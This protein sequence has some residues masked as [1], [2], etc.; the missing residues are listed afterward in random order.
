MTIEMSKKEKYERVKDA[1]L[2]DI[3]PNIWVIF[4]TTHKTPE[5]FILS[6]CAILSLSGFYSGAKDTNKNTYREFIK[7]LFPLPY[8]P[9]N[10]PYNA[11]HLYFDIRC[12]LIHAYT[13]PKLYIM[14]WGHLELHLTKT[15]LNKDY[16]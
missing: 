4:E 3:L 7:D 14:T 15:T 11:D 5:V 6:H 12:N 16:P 10:L 9:D 8:N 2:N 13:I 1:Y